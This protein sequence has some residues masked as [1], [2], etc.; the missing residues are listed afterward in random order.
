MVKGKSYQLLACGGNRIAMQKVMLD[1]IITSA[2][3]DNIITYL[4]AIRL[5]CQI[6]L[7]KIHT[8]MI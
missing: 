8:I 2:G 4:Y 1:T 5:N 3:G 7:A 6:A